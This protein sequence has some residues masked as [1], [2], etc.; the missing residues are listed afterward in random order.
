MG[1]ILLHNYFVSSNKRRKGGGLTIFPGFRSDFLQLGG[2]FVWQLKQILLTYVI[3]F[4]SIIFRLTLDELGSDH[5]D[6]V[7]GGRDTR[8]KR[9]E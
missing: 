4:Q 8:R 1:N 7:D 2:C 9:G 5:P 6:V 3:S